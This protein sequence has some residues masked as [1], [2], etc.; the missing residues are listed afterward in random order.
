MLY[1]IVATFPV[2]FWPGP[3]PAS[4]RHF[5]D[6]P[7]ENSYSF[8]FLLQFSCFKLL[9]P[10]SVYFYFAACVVFLAEIVWIGLREDFRVVQSWAILSDLSIKPQRLLLTPTNLTLEMHV[11]GP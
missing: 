5:N 4:F 3:E 1:T 7:S 11:P 2:L 10:R 6:F 8:V 9:L